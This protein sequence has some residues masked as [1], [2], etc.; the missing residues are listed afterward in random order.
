MNHRPKFKEKIIKLLEENIGEK[1]C[2]LGL[3]KY[4]KNMTPK[5]WS[6]K[7]QINKLDF[8]EVK[9]FLFGRYC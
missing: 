8:I 3:G 4:L 5:E 6:I 2:D 7:A 1:L 9:N